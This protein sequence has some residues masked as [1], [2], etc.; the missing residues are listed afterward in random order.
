MSHINVHIY[1]ILSVACLM[2]ICAGRYVLCV[3]CISAYAFALCRLMLFD[4]HMVKFNDN[5]V[6]KWN[7]VKMGI[8]EAYIGPNGKPIPATEKRGEEIISELGEVFKEESIKLAYLFGSRARSEADKNSDVDIGILIDEKRTKKEK[9]DI[10]K[11]L[12]LKIRKVLG[13]ERFDL[14]F[15]EDVS[16]V[17]KYEVISEGKVI[18]YED[19]STINDFEMG[20]LRTYQDTNYLRKVQNTYL[21]ERAKEWSSKKKA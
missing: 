18:Y 20:V 9:Y 13:S 5:N 19:E 16:P 3:G 10:L 7:V 4:F 8:D 17:F 21:R 1:H 2:C 11:A 6:N 14:V 12:Y 15:L